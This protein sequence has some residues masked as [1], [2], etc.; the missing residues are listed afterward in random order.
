LSPD[1]G[2]IHAPPFDFPFLSFCSS[3]LS[4]VRVAF[5]P[6]DW[7]LM[8]ARQDCFRWIIWGSLQLGGM[9]NDGNTVY[10]LVYLHVISE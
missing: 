9:D 4:S 6:C 3:L 5:W 8:S 10:S 7:V 2:L 1:W